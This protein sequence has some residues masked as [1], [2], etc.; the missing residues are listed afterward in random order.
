MKKIFRVTV[1]ILLGIL[2][3]SGLVVL[4]D[5]AEQ[6]HHELPIQQGWAAAEPIPNEVGLY[7]T[8]QCAVEPQ[9]IYILGGRIAGGIYTD[10]VRRYDAISDTWQTLASLP[11]VGAFFAS[12]CYQ[13]HI[14]V[15]GGGADGTFF[16]TL[17]IYDIAAGTWT[18][19]TELSISVAGATLGAWDDYLYLIGGNSLPGPPR[20]IQTHVNR[21]DI[22]AD[23]WDFDWGEEMPLA[24]LASSAQAGPFIYMV[25][26][27]MTSNATNSNATMRYDMENDEWSLGPVFDSRRAGHGLA[28]TEQHLHAIGGDDNGGTAWDAAADVERLD[29]T[30]WPTGTWETVDPLPQPT[31]GNTSGACTGAMTGG[32]VWSTGGAIGTDIY[33]SANVYMTAEP[34]YTL[35]YSMAT[36]PEAMENSGLPGQS[37]SYNLTISNT[38]SAV[39]SYTV[40][41][42]GD[43]SVTAAATI[44]PIDP[45]QSSNLVVTVTVPVTAADG[46]MDVATVTVTSFAE[47]IQQATATLTTTAV[48]KE[49]Y[50]PILMN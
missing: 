28:V 16:N 18:T 50:L 19:G 36:T 1:P 40:T 7:G 31:L 21:Y 8:A 46:D 13:D 26:G 10:T 38:G 43:W 6:P 39:D 42:S 12:T 9:N 11:R 35:S 49:A 45:Y 24:T 5:A 47:P 44:G 33:T 2:M 41:V 30:T 20:L 23:N 4:V 48:L 3:I 15:A 22:E 25:G 37:V 34:C 29:W 14:Y 27:Y 17:F 32:E